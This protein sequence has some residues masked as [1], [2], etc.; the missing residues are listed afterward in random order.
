MAYHDEIAE[1]LSRELGN[2]SAP[3]IGAKEWPQEVAQAV[4]AT[5]EKTGAT[6]R[7]MAELLKVPESRIWRWK[8]RIQFTD[9][10]YLQSV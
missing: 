8:D 7:L 2:S 4:L 6:A 9:T 1:T 5:M 3:V 10:K